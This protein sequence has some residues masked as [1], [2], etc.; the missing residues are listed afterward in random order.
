M[1][2]MIIHGNKVHIILLLPVSQKNRQKGAL[3][4]QALYIPDLLKV[5]LMVKVELT[6]LH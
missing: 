4:M 5:K 6:I 3:N 1:W 2:K